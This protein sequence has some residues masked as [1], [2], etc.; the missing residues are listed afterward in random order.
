[1]RIAISTH[2]PPPVMIES[3]ELRR[4]V[5]HMLCWSWAMYFSVAASSENDQVLAGFPEATE[6]MRPQEWAPDHLRRMS[7]ADGGA[8]AVFPQAAWHVALLKAIHAQECRR[9]ADAKVTAVVVELKR[10]KLGKLA[11]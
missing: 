3:T 11:E 5:T 9:A 1:M 8:G 6:G 10:V 4:W 2:F 7:R